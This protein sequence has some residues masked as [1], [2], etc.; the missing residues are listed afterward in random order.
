MSEE[1]KKEE[2]KEVIEEKTDKN[3]FGKI[4]KCQEL[5]GF[6][7]TVFASFLGALI[8]LC[9]YNAAAR[10]S[11]PPPPPMKA[12]PKIHQNVEHGRFDNAP[13]CEHR[14]D[15]KKFD[16]QNFDRKKPNKEN[17]AFENKFYDPKYDLIF[18]KTLTG[19][20]WNK[21][22]GRK[23]PPMNIDII[24]NGNT[25]KKY[26]KEENMIMKG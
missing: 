16:G 23:K 7:L 20:K 11:F 9:L 14:F 13:C 3:S 24:D 5:S 4:C 25:C 17:D 1:I 10:P 12:M 2:I 15:A 18:S 8:A 22:P 21:L 26:I 6:L 19:I